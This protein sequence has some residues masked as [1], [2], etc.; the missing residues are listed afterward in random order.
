MINFTGFDFDSNCMPFL[1]IQRASR[2]SLQKSKYCKIAEK[3]FCNKIA[4]FLIGKIVTC[5]M[6]A[7]AYHCKITEKILSCKGLGSD[8][9]SSYNQSFFCK[10]VY[11]FQNCRFGPKTG[12]DHNTLKYVFCNFPMIN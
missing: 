4:C 12:F 5:A 7:L 10:T 1:T 2:Q 3:L 9:L 6:N 11:L 8:C